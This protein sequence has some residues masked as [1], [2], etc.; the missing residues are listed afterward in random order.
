M[1]K[2]QDEKVS[3]ELSCELPRKFH[4]C[5]EDTGVSFGGQM[6]EEYALDRYVCMQKNIELYAR[7]RK[8]ANIS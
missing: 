6:M 1:I 4:L 3:T 5:G 2:R 8:S 7:H